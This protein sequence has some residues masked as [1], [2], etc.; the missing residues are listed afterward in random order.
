MSVFEKM[1][2]IADAIRSKTGGSEP[3]TLDGMAS[4]VNAVY[5][6][7]KTDAKAECDSKHFVQTF[8]GNNQNSFS[9]DIPFDPDVVFIV[10]HSAYAHTMS[11]V[12]MDVRVN[13]RSASRFM[14]YFMYTPSSGERTNVRVSAAAGM[15]ALA[16]VDGV[17]RFTCPNSTA[18]QAA[19]WRSDCQYVFTAVRYT[20]KTDA[21]LL[22]E[23]IALFSAAGG[24][25][26]YS[27]KRINEIFE[28]SAGANDGSESVAWEALVATKP[29]WTFSLV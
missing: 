12:W 21:Q 17:F 29:N 6:I 26:E 7:G 15:T 1:T 11:N 2:A 14:G 16:Y 20:D 10:C 8:T 28:T 9:L 18:M 5:V 19:I 24:T 23:E 27:L 25:V 13:R 4:G 22:S 3:I